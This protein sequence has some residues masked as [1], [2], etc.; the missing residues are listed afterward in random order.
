MTFPIDVTDYK[1]LTL[2]PSQRTLREGQKA[3]LARNIQIVRDTIVFYTAVAGAKGLGGH[4]GGA[5]SI[6]PEILIA[7]GFMRA[8][9]AI[10][11]ALFDEAGHRVA[12]Q[13][14]MLAFNG[15]MP[16]ENLLHYREYGRKLYG[17]PELDRELGVT[18]SSG[19]LGHLWAFVNGVAL[20]HRDK[21][22][23]LFSSDGSQQEGEDAEAARLALAQ[24][25][26]VKVIIDDNNVT[27][28]GHPR[29]YLPGYD[30]VRTLEGHG[31]TVLAGDGEDV[32]SLYTR[33][34]QAMAGP[35]PI[36]IINKRPMAP[37]IEGLEGSSKGHD[38]IPV[39]LALAY[40][41]AKGHTEAIAYL[42]GVTKASSSKTYLGSSREMKKNRDEFGKIVCEML[43]KMPP[44][45]RKQKVVVVDSDLEGS[46]GLHHIHKNFPELFVSGGIAERGSF[47]A[48]AGFGFEQGK[49]GIYGTFSAFLEM[50]VSEITMARLNEA[51]VIAHF[52]HAGVD[53][54]AD[55]TCHFGLNNF[56]A[57]TGLLDDDTTRLYFPADLNQ[58]KALMACIWDD[59]GLRFVFSTRSGVPLILE[60]NGTAFFDDNYTFVSGKYDVIRKGT[61]GYVVSYGELLYRALD[62]VEHCRA[63][64][65]DVGL[66][67]RPT[68]N[69]SDD[70]ETF[71]MIGKAPFVLVVE[72]QNQLTGLG[73][74]L[75]T[76]LLKA[77]FTPRYD[78]MGTVRVGNG[79]LSEQISHQGLDPDSIKKRIIALA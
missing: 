45:E 73:V 54:I 49:Q 55:N 59:P 68:L 28:A 69:W 47:S 62:A 57:A 58:L 24:R 64:G 53:D 76:G 18:F 19:R 48:A 61:A 79:G 51:N 74:R 33:M 38:V 42:K 7:D 13:Y 14:A 37:G 41:D 9:D 20:A 70:V 15:V 17:H 50:V 6:V 22:V 4:T 60:E 8:S 66:A 52:S 71:D 36:A 63:E 46:C 40:L 39:G 25:L 32:D 29:E 34:Q 65:L 11:P 27:I 26:N 75:G 72:G 78:H 12:I 5:Y 56:F 10:Y 44:Q 43:E 1:P 31:L 30:L 23:V 2:D 3:Q 67:N 77:G 35:G 21:T 16:F